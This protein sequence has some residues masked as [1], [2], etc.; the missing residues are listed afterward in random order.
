MYSNCTYINAYVAGFML[1]IKYIKLLWNAL[2]LRKKHRIKQTLKNFNM[3]S[4]G[5]TIRLPV[6]LYMYIPNHTSTDTRCEC[7]TNN[8]YLKT[9]NSHE[10]TLFS[11]RARALVLACS[12]RM[13]ANLC[14]CHVWT[15]TGVSEENVPRSLRWSC[16]RQSHCSGRHS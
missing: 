14:V 9:T 13:C 16:R 15:S 10:T 7:N 6:F 4:P 5:P 12:A 1:R 8:P 11:C 2:S 3:K